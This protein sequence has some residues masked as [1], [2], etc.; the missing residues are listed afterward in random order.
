MKE[1]DAWHGML[2]SAIGSLSTVVGVLWRTLLKRDKDHAKAVSD[3]QVKLD[4]SHGD[5]VADVKE[6]TRETI[7]LARAATYAPPLSRSGS[8]PPDSAD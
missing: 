6:L 1:L 4:T 3:L 8:R 2:L 5:H 7:E